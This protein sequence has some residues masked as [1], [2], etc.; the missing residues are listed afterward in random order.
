MK[1]ITLF[2]FAIAV[3][4][5]CKKDTVNK[6]EPPVEPPPVTQISQK[7]LV[8]TNIHFPGADSTFTIS[9]DPSKGN[10]VLAGFSGDVYAHI[11]AITNLSNGLTDWKY[12]KAAWEVNDPSAKLVRQSNGIYTLTIRPRNFLNVPAG[13]TILKLAM[14]FRNANGTMVGRN[15]DGSDI[16]IPLY[17]NSSLNVRFIEPEMHPTFDPK[18]TLT[19]TTVGQEITVT[20]VASQKANLSLTLNGTAFATATSST[21]VT[22][23]AKITVGGLQTIKV[24]ANN[25]VENTISFLIGGAAVVES[26]PT[27][28]KP[29][30]TFINGGAS[31][32]FAL[33]APGKQ[34]VNV[35]GDFNNWTADRFMKKTPDGNIWWMQ[36]D[37]LNPNTEY[38][39]QYLVDGTLKI[40]DPYSEKVLDPDNDQY[41]KSSGNNWNFGNYPSGKTTGIVSMMK[42]NTI[43]YNW[44]HTAFTRL[45]K[46]DLVIYE[47]HLR[48]FLAANNYKTLTDTINYLTRLGVNAVELMPVNEFEGNS[49]WGYNP[50]F[51]FAP[52]KFYGSKTDLQRFIDECH[53]KGIAVILD[54]VLNHSFGQNPMVQLYF[55]GTKPANSPWFN[56]S[57][58]H[59][60]NVGYDFNHESPHTR[61]FVKDVIKFWMQEYK[62]DGFR[63]DLSKGFTQ[64]NTGSNVEAWNKKDDSRINIWK[65]YN[66]YIKSIDANNFYVI[67]EH[68]AEDA[69]EQILASEGMMLWNNVNYSFNEAS[70]GWLKD[71]NGNYGQSDFKRGI[72]TQ[73]NFSSADNLI[74]Y[75][76]SHDE[77]RMM[78]KNIS[79]GNASG[80]YSIK[81]LST[82]LK[83]QE[84][85]A[86]F[87]FAIPGPKMLWQ[88]GEMGYE[89]SI[90]QNGRTGEKP[91]LWQYNTQPSR[92]ALRNA[93]AKFINLKKKNPVYRTTNISFDFL[94]AV[95]YIKLTQGATTVVV[96]GNFDVTSHQANINFGA[97][98]NWYD[99]MENNQ[100]MNLAGTIYTK[101]LLPGEY[102]IYSTTI[103]SE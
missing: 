5:S 72:Y 44:R 32:I 96:V 100:V 46:S 26:L 71:D 68:F 36:I 59:P 21:Q 95:K 31:A 10:A 99:V 88:F 64:T 74:T 58:T 22:G 87:L 80:S 83:R 8:T 45:A 43:V 75:M 50:S 89:I 77:E 24:I 7:G 35:I 76:E 12:T 13:E 11:G 67:L 91:L 94:G 30:V 1:R 56:A 2:A 37:Q 40:A 60:F 34:F 29:G 48:D 98:G 14:V 70:M 28:A 23:K 47:L 54:M 81:E 84:M 17:N 65:D 73:H 61:K 69:E 103:L 90:D 93:F 18:P 49:S 39:Y 51:Y 19:L 4:L 9:F 6:T 53:G 33:Y 86:A 102:H 42:A 79:Y 66:N 62:V 20:G 25:S 41:I 52:D 78:F 55:D 97:A 38:A 101:T 3:L 82:A 85:S 27:G 57:P 63:F 92:V 15:S 16:F